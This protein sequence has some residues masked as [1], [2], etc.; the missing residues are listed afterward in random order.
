LR[1]NDG[2]P[3]ANGKPLGKLH[4]FGGFRRADTRFEVVPLVEVKQPDA[5]YVCE[6][7]W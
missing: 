3:A 4:E 5:L 7:C 1:R 6:W 2:R